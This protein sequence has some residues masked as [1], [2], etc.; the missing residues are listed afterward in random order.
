MRP[1]AFER[2]TMPSAPSSPTDAFR[3]WQTYRLVLA[4]FYAIGERGKVD[5]LATGENEE[6]REDIGSAKAR[7][8][9]ANADELGPGGSFEARYH[10]SLL[11][12]R[13]PG[14]TYLHL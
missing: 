5:A 6:K 4:T 1:R 8:L 14:G 2:M 11:F 12:L 9:N 13:S 7:N 3:L 10:F